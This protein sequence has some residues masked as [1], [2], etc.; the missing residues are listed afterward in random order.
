[1]DLLISPLLALPLALP[2]DDERV[3]ISARLESESLAPGTEAAFVLTLELAEGVSGSDSGVPAPLIQLDVPPSV[4]LEG[5]VSS[6]YRALSRNEFLVEP[7]ERL[8]PEPEARIAFEL[9]GEPAAGDT[10]G[11]SVVGYFA[12]EPG[13]DDFFVRRR[14]ELPL[15]AGA[16]ASPGSA[17][18]SSW[19]A[20][21]DVLQIGDELPSLVLSRADGTEH[22]LTALAGDGP[23]IVTTYRA[24]W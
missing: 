3:R 6:S 18:D 9:V 2:V 21:E 19:S 15:V 10:I 1:M 14:L 17:A 5:E 7:F 22:E 12:T 20:V 8:M 24:F 4:K 13:E 23:M 16:E 11:I